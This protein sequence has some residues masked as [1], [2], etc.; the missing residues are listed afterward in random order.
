M[1][2]GPFEPM[3]ARDLQMNVVQ[4]ASTPG[5]GRRIMLVAVLALVGSYT[6]GLFME[7]LAKEF[8]WGR[9][10]ISAGLLVTSL[11]TIPMSPFIGALIDRW[12][13]R[14]LAIP[15]MALA[16]AAVASFAL[17]N[18]NTTQWLLL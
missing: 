2:F 14:R 8:G 4:S 16:I 6:T 11:M 9:A 13:S 10:Q 7:P 5:R 17:A 3:S 12:G 15:G 18:G 1:C